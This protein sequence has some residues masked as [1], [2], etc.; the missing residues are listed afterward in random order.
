MHNP[1]NY[2][3]RSRNVEYKIQLKCKKFTLTTCQLNIYYSDEIQIKFKLLN[4]YNTDN[5]I[6]QQI[7][8]II[9]Y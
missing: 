1:W 2:S 8:L 4:H 3:K 6:Q 7:R 9:F 5:N